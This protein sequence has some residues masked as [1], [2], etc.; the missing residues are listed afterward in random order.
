MEHSHPLVPAPSVC[1]LPCLEWENTAGLE[2]VLFQA[3]GATGATHISS[4]VL[5]PTSIFRYSVLSIEFLEERR[6]G[7]APRAVDLYPL[8]LSCLT[9]ASPRLGMLASGSTILTLF[10]NTRTNLASSKPLSR[11]FTA[12]L[13]GPIFCGLQPSM[14]TCLSPNES[15]SGG[16]QFEQ[17]GKWH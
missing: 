13:T 17:E 3:S 7:G 2:F 4:P 8:T 9:N 5:G 15:T 14:E 6:R 11:D 16:M 12:T 10:A 1:R